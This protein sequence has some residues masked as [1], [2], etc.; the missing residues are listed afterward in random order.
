MSELKAGLPDGAG[1]FEAELFM[2]T[3]AAFVG[4][5]NA[6]NHRGIAF[7]L[8]RCEQLFHELSCDAAAAIVR[9]HIDGVLDGI[10]VGSMQNLVGFWIPHI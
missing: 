5:I 6:C 10:F 1:I 4:G 9:M 7:F 3:D 8:S 2:Q